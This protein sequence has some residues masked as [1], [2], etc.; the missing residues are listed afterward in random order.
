MNIVIGIVSWLPDDFSIRNRRFEKL[1][2]LVKKCNVLF[3]LPIIIIAQNWTEADFKAIEGI[4]YFKYPK[5]GIVGAR[6]ALRKHFLESNFDYLIMLDDDCTLTGD[7]ESGK[8]YLEQIEQHPG[9]FGEF[10]KTLLKLFAISR[11]LFSLESFDENVLPENGDGFE[12]RIFVNRLRHKYPDKKFTFIRNGLDEYSIVTADKDS[13]WYSDQDIA[14]MLDNT[15]EII[16]K[17]TLN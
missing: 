14:K 5:L 4:T 16:Q 7:Y 11:E 15:T 8:K 6:N 9:M 17:N 12:D 2:A 10:R 13:T 1:K 3:N